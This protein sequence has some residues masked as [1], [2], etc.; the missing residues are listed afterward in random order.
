VTGAE[1]SITDRL[2]HDA[3]DGDA[4]RNWLLTPAGPF[5]VILRLN[6]PKPEM[7]NGSYQLPQIISDK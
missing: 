4:A 5:Y 3:P 7:L 1:G 2:Q 6:Q